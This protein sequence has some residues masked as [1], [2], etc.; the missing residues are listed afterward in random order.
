MKKRI[1]ILLI[2]TAVGAVAGVLL[3]NAIFSLF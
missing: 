1:I 2:V 3:C